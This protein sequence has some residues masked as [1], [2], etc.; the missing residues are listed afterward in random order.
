MII[1]SLKPYNALSN[2][3]KQTRVDALTSLPNMS[4]VI[5]ALRFL[6]G[7]GLAV[8]QAFFK[9]KFCVIDTAPNFEVKAPTPLDVT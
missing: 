9:L 2:K 3:F 4:T 8:L 6:E 5:S 7:F 1:K